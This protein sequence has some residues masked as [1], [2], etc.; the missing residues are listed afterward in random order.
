MNP[1]P[2]TVASPSGDC[3]AERQPRHDRLGD[4]ARLL[5][6]R[7]G[8]RQRDVGGEVAMLRTLGPIDRDRL[9]GHRGDEA[10][11][12]ELVDRP[13]ENFPNSFTRTERSHVV[14]L[15]VVSMHT[16]AAVKF[17]QVAHAVA[18]AAGSLDREE[19]AAGVVVLEDRLI[20]GRRVPTVDRVAQG[21]DAQE[22]AAGRPPALLAPEPLLVHDE[23]I[24]RLVRAG[25]AVPVV[26][27]A[28]ESTGPRTI[29]AGID[30]SMVI[31]SW[32][33]CAA[34]PP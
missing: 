23:E 22:L 4:G 19:A 20:A 6:R 26:T 11:A 16:W 31:G 33:T 18:C 13:D 29:R 32:T 12:R 8:Q 21:I 5:A 28:S 30:T 34:N 7:L 10:F 9:A 1:G 24:R 17:R 27:C 14:H 15:H 3:P 2:A 25:V